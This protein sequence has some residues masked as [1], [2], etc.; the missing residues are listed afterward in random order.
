MAEY[1]FAGPVDVIAHSF[2]GRIAIG[3]AARHPQRIGRLVLIGSAGLR[4]RRSLS[5]RLKRVWG[6]TLR[7]MA[8]VVGGE[9]AAKIE[10]ARVRLGSEDWRRASP[11]MRGTLS[12]VLDEEMTQELRN[13]FHPTLLLWGSRDSATPLWM[14]RAMALLI[15]SAELVVVQ[16]AGHYPFLDRPGEALSAIW[17]HLDLPAAW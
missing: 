13:I 12:R 16:G 9:L 4:P 17:K 11:V 1:P 7:R 2:G 14:G 15:P 10:S 6:R 5:V 8:G 3:L